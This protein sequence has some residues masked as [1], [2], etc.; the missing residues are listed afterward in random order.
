[1]R[2]PKITAAVCFGW[3]FAVPLYAE[4]F[5]PPPQEWLLERANEEG[6]VVI[7]SFTSRI[8]EV[9]PAFEAAYPGIDLQ[10]YDIPSTDQIAMLKAEAASGKTE[11]DVVLIADAPSVIDELVKDYIVVPYVPPR[12]SKRVPD[13]FR[14]PLM[15]QRLATK[16]LMYNEEA[17][18]DGAPIDNIWQLTTPEWRGR[19]IMVDPLHRG[20]YLDLM[21]EFTL[22]DNAMATAYFSNFGR[23]LHPQSGVGAGEQFVID[24]LANDV[25]FV[26]STDEA[27]RLVGEQGQKDPPV[28]FSS[29][30]DVRNNAVSGWA[31]QVANDVVPS[32]GIMFPAML[33]LG[34]RVD[35][36]AAAR[37]LIDYLMGDD[38]ATGGTAFE[39]FY[40]PGDYA[41]RTDI[42]PHPQAIPFEDFRAWRIDPEL[43]AESRQEVAGLIRTQRQE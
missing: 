6:K 26:D 33:A 30:S 4:T 7:Y 13:E 14:R 36:P 1:M 24:L 11:A 19:V 27:N 23:I 20:D 37:V 39:P 8:A 10:G 28:A 34:K 18:P 12:L 21:T 25:V 32:P 3:M 43:T 16:V 5:E 22:Q 31:L 29:Y 17:N 15:A 38:S 41:T 2:I 42:A 40:V 35:N 9:E